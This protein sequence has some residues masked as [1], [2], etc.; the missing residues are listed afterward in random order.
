M[1]EELI[2]GWDWDWFRS[3]VSPKTLRKSVLKVFYHIDTSKS[4][5]LNLFASQF[6]QNARSPGKITSWKLAS[7]K[8]LHLFELRNRSLLSREFVGACGKGTLQPSLQPLPIYIHVIPFITPAYSRN[9][10]N[11]SGFLTAHHVENNDDNHNNN[12]CSLE[13]LTKPNS[14]NFSSRRVA[15]LS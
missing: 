11:S 8:F 14:P 3:T 2:N 13:S 1:L 7:Q 4:R 6:F 9:P 5:N 15:G 10:R 12:T